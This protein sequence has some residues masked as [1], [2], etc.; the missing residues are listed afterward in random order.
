[1]LKG[2]VKL[3]QAKLGMAVVLST[4]V[5]GE[6]G[7]APAQRQSK[8]CKGQDLLVGTWLVTVAAG[9]GSPSFT[10]FETY[11]ASGAVTAI[12]NQA[13][14]CSAFAAAAAKRLGVYIT[15]TTS[16]RSKTSRQRASGMARQ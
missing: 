9:D 5:A 13:W 2:I 10:V 4:V 7:F 6:V 16:T 11:A 15:A 1:M 14:H 8:G 3:W 12:D